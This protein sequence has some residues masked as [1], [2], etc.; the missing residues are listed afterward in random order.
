MVG[1][2]S[3]DIQD[4]IRLV[5]ARA[6]LHAWTGAEEAREARSPAGII[7]RNQVARLR[8]PAMF[9]SHSLGGFHCGHGFA[10]T[11]L[12]DPKTS[13]A[14]LFAATRSATPQPNVSCRETTAPH[15][16]RPSIFRPPEALSEVEVIEAEAEL[17]ALQRHALELVDPEV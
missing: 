15:W 1:I 6:T 8:A 7:S 16:T 12:F 2:D 9:R 5:P 3:K 13:R 14:Y 4:R 11:F 10:L 17:K